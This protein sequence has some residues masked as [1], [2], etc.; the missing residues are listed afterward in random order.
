MK[1]DRRDGK[2]RCMKNFNGKSF[3]RIIAIIIT[4]T[5]NRVGRTYFGKSFVFFFPSDLMNL[6]KL[7]SSCLISRAL[8]RSAVISNF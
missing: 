8:N 7:N 3:G 5:I 1:I 4:T 6:N 2:N